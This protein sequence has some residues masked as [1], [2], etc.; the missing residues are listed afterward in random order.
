MGGVPR[1]SSVGSASPGVLRRV[2]PEVFPPTLPVHW[3]NRLLVLL[4]AKLSSPFLVSPRE[5]RIPRG[6]PTSGRR[7][8]VERHGSP[9]RWCIEDWESQLFA[10]VPLDG[11]PSCCCSDDWESQ[12]VRGS[13]PFI[14]SRVRSA[15][16]RGAGEFD[17]RATFSD[18]FISST[19]NESV[20][21]SCRK[22][23]ADVN[24]QSLHRS[25]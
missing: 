21:L 8:F 5:Y 14:S 3:R 18:L 4:R 2:S 20:R 1:D 25:S 22:G 10:G 12:L 23:P 9:I 11:R 13:P 24:A 19:R 15:A 16:V 6:S 17:Q 7:L